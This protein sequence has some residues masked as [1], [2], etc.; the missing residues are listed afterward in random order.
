M[1]LLNEYTP[2]KKKM[3]D[4]DKDKMHDIDK[5]IVIYVSVLKLGLGIVSNEG[6][7]IAFMY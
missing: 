1:P 2:K 3:H 6:S 7:V 5:D 4:I